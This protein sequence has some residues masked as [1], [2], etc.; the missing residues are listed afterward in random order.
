MSYEFDILE[1][2]KFNP[3]DAP[4]YSKALID[5]VLGSVCAA[6]AQLMIVKS[7]FIP[8]PHQQH[9]CGAGLSSAQVVH[10]QRS[11]LTHTRH[12][13]ATVAFAVE[14]AMLLF[15]L[16]SFSEAVFV[17]SLIG[18]CWSLAQPG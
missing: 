14:A 6:N 8:K 13:R 15:S 17:G 3:L 12:S 10:A 9:W 1:L 11:E 4:L 2:S 16:F 7:L 18:D 5:G